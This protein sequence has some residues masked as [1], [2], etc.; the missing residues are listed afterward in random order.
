MIIEHFKKNFFDN[1]KDNK[2]KIDH[3]FFNDT[4]AKTISEIYSYDYSICSLSIMFKILKMLEIQNLNLNDQDE[5]KCHGFISEK[6]LKNKDTKPMNIIE[7]FINGN[8]QAIMT[9]LYDNK[10]Q[11]NNYE[12]ENKICLSLF[13]IKKIIKDYSFY[14]DKYELEKILKKLK[15]FKE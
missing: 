14:F 5:V 7:V 15:K 4:Y 13:I 2:N 8:L 10:N 3:C 1:S 11:A 12:L 9:D 6:N